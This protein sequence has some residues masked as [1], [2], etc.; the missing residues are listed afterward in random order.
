MSTAPPITPIATQSWLSVHAARIER[1]VIVSLVLLVTTYGL[2]RYFDARVAAT[3]ARAT[4]AEQ[5][6]AAEKATDA[7]NAIRASTALSQYEAELAADHTLIASLAA[8]AAA[9]QAQVTQ[10][11]KA[12]STLKLPDLANR[13][14]TLGNAPEGSVTTTG[15]SVD[16][17]P[18]GALAVTQTLEQIPALQDDLK[19]TQAAL[20]SS[21]GALAQAGQAIDAQTTQI[22]GLKLTIAGEEA[23]CK[24]QVAVV[25]AQLKSSRWRYFKFGFITG[26]LTGAYVGHAL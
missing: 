6:L 20:T 25:K 24:A 23:Q 18:S 5:T 13:L 12:D 19:D 4:Q 2:G 14:K 15:T 22:A 3:E 10:Q 9:R 16:F 7:E 11:I 8:T 1:V 17:T 21:Q 26:F